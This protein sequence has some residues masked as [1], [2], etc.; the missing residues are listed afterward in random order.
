MLVAT[1]TTSIVIDRCDHL[2]TTLST[3]VLPD[4]QRRLCLGMV[5]MLSLDRDSTD[6]LTLQE[7]LP[8]AWTDRQRSNTKDWPTLLLVRSVTTMP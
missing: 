6:S 5:T 8:M 2:V 7:A 3:A 1:V 4:R